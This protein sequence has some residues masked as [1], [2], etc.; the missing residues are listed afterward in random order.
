MAK[1]K[2]TSSA[3]N[4]QTMGDI[5]PDEDEKIEKFVADDLKWEKSISELK[6]KKKAN[7]EALRE[8]VIN[9]FSENKYDCR[10]SDRTVRRAKEDIVRIEKH[11]NN[12]E[13]G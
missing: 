1:A 2:Q 7:K 8:Y 4:Q 11:A 12:G 9:E 10:H 6:I 13:E 5:V 3:K